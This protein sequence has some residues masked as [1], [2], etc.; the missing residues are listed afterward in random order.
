ME[1]L[2]KIKTQDEGQVAVNLN[3]VEVTEKTFLEI[4]D[5]LKFNKG[6]MEP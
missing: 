6:R 1:V 5:A 3:N 4:F 2:E